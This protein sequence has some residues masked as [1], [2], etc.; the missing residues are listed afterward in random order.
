MYIDNSQRSLFRLLSI[1]TDFGVQVR[2]V[3]GF[4]GWEEGHS[5][6]L[7]RKEGK[8]GNGHQKSINTGDIHKWHN[9]CKMVNNSRSC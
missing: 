8:K 6:I 1:G 5:G 3:D 7:A 2:Q 9:N 4:W